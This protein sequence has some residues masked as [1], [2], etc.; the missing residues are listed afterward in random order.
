MKY[1]S[2][3]IPA[4][5]FFLFQNLLGKK[6]TKPKKVPLLTA[7][8]MGVEVTSQDSILFFNELCS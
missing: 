7:V 8:S 2:E 5:N 3:K 4:L 6:K 1:S